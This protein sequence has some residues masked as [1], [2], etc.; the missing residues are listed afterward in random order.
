MAILN[1]SFE[2]VGD[3]SYLE[4]DTAGKMSG[5]R[6]TDWADDG[7]WSYKLHG[8]SGTTDGSNCRIVQN[9]TITKNAL[10]LKARWWIDTVNSYRITI[11]FGSDEL[12]SKALNIASTYTIES[13][14]VDTTNYV[15]QTDDL[16]LMLVKSSGNT[17]VGMVYWD[18]L[19]E[20]KDNYYVK[21]TGDD[22]KDGLSWTNAW[23]TINKAATTI[24]DGTTVHIGFGTYDAEPATNKIAPQNIGALGIY[25]LPETETTGGGTGTVSVEQN[26]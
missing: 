6:S 1:P 11:K 8:L 25:Y 14:D 23:K 7:S 18:N 19:I 10:K 21:T 12:Y 9:V 20:Y 17:Q 4:S 2:S 16:I 13:I 24:A 5:A 26:A 3:W 22:S 15:G